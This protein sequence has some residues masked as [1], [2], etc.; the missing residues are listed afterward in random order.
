[1]SD[2][3][4]SLTAWTCLREV[5]NIPSCLFNNRPEFFQSRFGQLVHSGTAELDFL[6]D[7]DG[8][9]TWSADGKQ[10]VWK[11]GGQVRL[12]ELPACKQVRR[13]EVPLMYG[14]DNSALSPDGKRLV[15]ATWQGAISAESKA[16]SIF[17]QFFRP[18]SE[19]SINSKQEN[20]FMFCTCGKRAKVRFA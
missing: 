9:P 2:G 14:Q 8:S 16:E 19:S 1:M 13:F 12:L 15:L 18:F 7:F 3:R 11:T 10:I 5:F 20:G 4:R 17:K 6:A